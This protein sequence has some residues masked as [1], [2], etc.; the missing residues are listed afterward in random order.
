[1]T[2]T[3]PAIRQPVA[4]LAV[5]MAWGLIPVV[6][7][8]LAIVVPMFVAVGVLTNMF[9]SGEFTTAVEIA[10]SGAMKYFPMAVAIMMTPAFL[11]VFVAQGVTRRYVAYG[12]AGFIGIWAGTFAVVMAI[13]Y[14][15]EALILRAAG[16]DQVFEQPHLFTRWSD[17]YLIVVEYLL[18]IGAH[19]M[20]G[21][22]IGTTYYRLRWFRA[23]LLLPLTVLP[24][25]AVEYILGTGWA[26]VA[27]N[28]LTS[29][30]RPTL[31][32]VIPAALLVIILAW[33]IN[34]TMIRNVPIR[35]KNG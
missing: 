2:R 4:R 15:I 32:V 10:G 8:F 17:S 16:I 9:G 24:A 29:Y 1:M 14:A 18:M 35:L 23:T 34:F 28:E 20:V 3:Y 26:G 21:W 19:L 30:S 5:S 7:I 12:G 13:G 6:A 33:T 22:L 27:L 31:A 11:P 25:L